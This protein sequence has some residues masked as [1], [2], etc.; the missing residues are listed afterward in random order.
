MHE[1]GLL[2]GV[3]TAVE[4]AATAAGD[5]TVTA[6]ALR[7]GALSGAVPEALVGAWPI[8]THGTP[9]AGARLE[10]EPVPAAVWCPRCAAEQPIDAFYALT[11]PVCDTPTGQLA[12]GREF[13][14]AWVEWDAQDSHSS[15]T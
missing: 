5:P 1:L 4:R 8:A 13:D 6:V 10:V 2:R 9:L 14:I 15:S 3:V 11:C 12:H 7:V